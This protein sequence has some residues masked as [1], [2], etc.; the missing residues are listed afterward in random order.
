[1]QPQFGLRARAFDTRTTVSV[2]A[3]HECFVPLLEDSAAKVSDMAALTIAVAASIH[4]P[5][6]SLADDHEI[7]VVALLKVAHDAVSKARLRVPRYRAGGAGGEQEEEYVHVLNRLWNSFVK[8]K[9]RGKVLSSTA[10]L[11]RRRRFG[12]SIVALALPG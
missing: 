9:G 2:A 6:K 11:R 8:K 3:S 1:M 4:S 12:E 10:H 7:L 5:P